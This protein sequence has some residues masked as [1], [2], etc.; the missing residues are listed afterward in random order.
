MV[1]LEEMHRR[2]GDIL[3][4]A[5]RHGI[6]NVRVFGSVLRGE[7]RENSDI[8]LLVDASEQTRLFDLMDAQEEK[9]SS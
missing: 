4:I 9:E 8:D 3:S 6:G 1:L 7:E 5:A 2:R